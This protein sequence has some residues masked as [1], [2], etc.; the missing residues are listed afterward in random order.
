MEGVPPLAVGEGNRTTFVL[1]RANAIHFECGI[2]R[3][4]LD[5]NSI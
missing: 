3:I 2:H 5:F 4:E 1:P